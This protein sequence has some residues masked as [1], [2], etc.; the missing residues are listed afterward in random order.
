MNTIAIAELFQSQLDEQLVGK[1]TSGW[2]EQNADKLVYTGN[3]TCRIPKMTTDGLGTYDRAGG[4]GYPTGSIV[5]SFESFTLEQLR[6]RKFMI[7]AR[8]VTESNFVASV[9]NTMS[10]FQRVSVAPEVDA[11]R[12]SK[13]ASLA[14]TNGRASGGYTPAVADIL[15][16]LKGDINAIQD[17]LG[18]DTPLVVTMSTK[19]LA[20]LEDS[21]EITRQLQVGTF[22]GNGD[23]VVPVTMCDG[24]PIIE[25][26]S[27]RLMT[28]YQFLDGKTVG[29]EAGGFTSVGVLGTKHINWLI[30]A[31]TAPIAIQMTDT[32]RIFDPLVVQASNS[33]QVDYL[34]YHDLFVEDNQF[35]AVF[36]NILEP[37]V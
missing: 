2:M 31:V 27:A 11:Y 36:A 15:K 4:T 5:S 20:I 26:P 19:T 34:K 9:G 17:V 24:C 28:A 8:D 33:W 14:I 25:V 13:L 29:Q 18:T 22:Q 6:G 3:G 30:T 32:I 1:L 12:Y 21:S 7:D 35:P 37:L 23:L 16:T 10:V